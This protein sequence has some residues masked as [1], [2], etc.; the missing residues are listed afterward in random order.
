MWLSNKTKKKNNG[1]NLGLRGEFVF[2]FVLIALIPLL[3]ASLIAYTYGKQA[4]EKTIGQGL[5]Q[6]AQEKLDHADHSIALRI[7]TIY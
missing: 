2:Q 6:V 3:L 5:V 1:L 7:D 4:L